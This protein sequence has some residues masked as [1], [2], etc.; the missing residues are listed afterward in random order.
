M[1]TIATTTEQSS[2]LRNNFGSTANRMFRFFRKFPEFRVAKFPSF[3]CEQS[4]NWNKISVSRMC[5]EPLTR[6]DAQ[7]YASRSSKTQRHAGPKFLVN[8]WT[9]KS[10]NV[11]SFALMFFAFVS[12]GIS[13]PRHCP[14]WTFALME[15]YAPHWSIIGVSKT[16]KTQKKINLF[17]HE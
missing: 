14:A 8:T 15:T 5:Q 17:E 1:L 10:R 16:W 11:E 2:E 9:P 7:L 3:F 13:V 6:F 4:A 12:S